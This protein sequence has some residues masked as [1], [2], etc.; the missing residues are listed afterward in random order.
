MLLQI[1]TSRIRVLPLVHINVRRAGAALIPL[2]GEP[3]SHEFYCCIEIENANRYFGLFSLQMTNRGHWQACISLYE[4]R[5]ESTE[6]GV[7]EDDIG[8]TVENNVLTIEATV[9]KEDLEGFDLVFTE[10]ALAN[11]R[12]QFSISENID[13]ETITAELKDGTLRLTMPK[14]AVHKPKTIKVQA[15]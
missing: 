14:R 9:S 8:I 4:V 1:Y 10:F 2:A 7:S 11:Y 13:I 3:A 12:R 5:D 15:V 6:A